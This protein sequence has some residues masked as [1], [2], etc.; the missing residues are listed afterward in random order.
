MKKLF[1]TSSSCVDILNQNT[2]GI[3]TDYSLIIKEMTM[4]QVRDRIKN[5]FQMLVNI[6]TEIPV[7]WLE[8]MILFFKEG[9]IRHFDVIDSKETK[10]EAGDLFIFTL[11]LK[12]NPTSLTDFKF[13]MG[14]VV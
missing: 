5:E 14:T 6:V 3:P 7:T 11:Q 12:Q 1:I 10:M 13:L 2:S 9:G 8:E 4:F